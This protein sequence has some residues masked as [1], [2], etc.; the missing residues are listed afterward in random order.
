MIRG[1]LFDAG[2]T[3][4]RANP[5]VEAV[6]LEA[7]SRDGARTTPAALAAALEATW[8]EI[9]ERGLPNRF[10]GAT[11]E[12]GF[13]EAFVRRARTH[14]DGGCLSN[15]CFDEL[16]QHFIRPE[17]WAVYPDVTPA[18]SDLRNRGY[19]LA[20]V[21]NWDSTLASLLESHGLSESFSAILISGVEKS[22]KPH[23]EI[24]SRACRRLGIRKDEALH[25]GDSLEEDYRAARAAGLS[26]LLLDR[27][28]RHPGIENRISTLAQLPERL[29]AL[30]ENELSLPRKQGSLP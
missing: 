11:G 30:A 9:R 5:P 25:V 27:D 17:S 10:G 22:A 24:F 19:A 21:S 12:R 23:P 6:Y 15:R 4:L 20:V 3:L 29:K 28:G 2:A 18:I 26:A 8:R 16:V 13:W 7:F 14:L 1:V